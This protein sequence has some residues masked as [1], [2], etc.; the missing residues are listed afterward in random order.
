[1]RS[2]PRGPIRGWPCLQLQSGGFI[3]ARQSADMAL[4]MQP[5]SAPALLSLGR[6]QAASGETNAAIIS[7]AKAA[8][9][10]HLP[11]AQWLLADALRAAG[12][13]AEGAAKSKSKSS[14]AAPWKTRDRFR[15]TFPPAGSSRN[16][17]SRW[18]NANLPL[19]QM[20]LRTTR[21]AWA[22]QAN[23]RFSEARAEMTK[24]LAD[25]TQDARLFFHA[26]VINAAAGEKDEAARCA[27]EAWSF[28]QMLYPSEIAQLSRVAALEEF[29]RQHV[30]NL[31][32]KLKDT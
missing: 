20:F 12:N 28:R 2:R 13:R 25:G 11:E 7:L 8:N 15:S 18:L 26:A 19:V 14:S 24:A 32:S 4:Q 3:N 17:R 9:L 27:R 1:M 21:C 10:N 16:W 30:S 29:S 6:I 5:E 22:L 23:G 31:K